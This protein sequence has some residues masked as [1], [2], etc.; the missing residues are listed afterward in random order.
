MC[1]RCFLFRDG[2]ADAVYEGEEECEVDCARDLGAMFKVE[3]CEVRYDAFECTIWRQE[4]KL[5]LICH[6]GM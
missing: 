3:V 6:C 2:I 5:G 1:G 4:A